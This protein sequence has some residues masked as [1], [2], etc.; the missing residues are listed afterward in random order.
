MSMPAAVLGDRG[1]GKTTFL[2]LLYATQIK[3][4]NEPVNKDNFRFY[5]TPT[6][7]N[8]MG[9]MFNHLRSGGWPEATMK[10]QQTKVSFLFGFKRLGAGAIPDWIKKREWINP[11]STIK[12]SVY[13]VAGEDVNDII[14]TP[15]GVFN[16][17]LPEEVKN[18][19]ESRILV[20]LVDASRITAKPRSKPYID[21]IEYDKKTATLISIIAK[22][23]SRKEDPKLRK[24]Y[25]IFVFTKFDCVE[26]NI[27]QG[28]RLK[29]KPP[30]YKED[31]DRRAFSETIMRNFFGQTLALIKGGKLMKVS[32]DYA[33]YF[34]SEINTEF[35]EDGIPIPSIKVMDDG[36]GHELD[37][38]YPEYRW[39]IDHFKKIA[40]SM[41][42]NIKEMQDFDS[43]KLD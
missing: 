18:L 42:D 14:R 31:D 27:L 43:G 16:E 40:N 15:D 19:L 23:N 20:V 35:N 22:Y 38:S 8:F 29:E 17:D 34:F 28:M 30:D 1:C 7:L 13:D 25:P 36:V 39:F 3:Y 2:A 12:F 11:F 9:D 32:F 41:P 5:A 10:G 6:S 24:I 21:M 33:A 26:D 4:T 37:F